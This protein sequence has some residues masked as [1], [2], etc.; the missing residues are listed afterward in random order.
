MHGAGKIGKRNPN[1]KNRLYSKE[2]GRPFFISIFK[3]LPSNNKRDN[4]SRDE[5]KTENPVSGYCFIGGSDM[6]IVSH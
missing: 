3:N 1:C 5:E 4:D 6:E 2:P